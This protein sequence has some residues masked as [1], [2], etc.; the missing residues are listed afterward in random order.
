M[1]KRVMATFLALVLV[2]GLSPFGAPALAETPLGTVV[3]AG[4]DDAGVTGGAEANQPQ[5]GAPSDAAESQPI[6]GAADGE[7][8]N[9]SGEDAVPSGD[10]VADDG[11]VSSGQE[12]TP[13]EGDDEPDAA[14]AAPAPAAQSAALADEPD[15]SDEEPA[16]EAA[17]QPRAGVLPI[18]AY[19][20]GTAD[21][22][23]V[24]HALGE[25][26][27]GSAG[28]Q[29]GMVSMVGRT[30]STPRATPTCAASTRVW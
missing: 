13:A 9:G 6:D 20:K 17:P 3:F 26:V 8:D 7:E 11:A 5:E 16:A 29:N 10:V 18:K 12:D 19:G 30:S 27:P 21:T 14:E 1:F 28:P 2:L 15:A 22:A 25:T 23:P 4:L 24:F